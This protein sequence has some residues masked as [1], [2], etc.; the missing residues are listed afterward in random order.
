MLGFIV[1]V[2]MCVARLLIAG[3]I[4]NLIIQSSNIKS[5]IEW[6][7]DPKRLV[8]EELINLIFKLVEFPSLEDSTQTEKVGPD[9]KGQVTENLQ[10]VEFLDACQNFRKI[11]IFIIQ[12]SVFSSKIVIQSMIVQMSPAAKFVI[13]VQSQ[14]L[15]IGLLAGLLNPNFLVP[16]SVSTQTMAE[17]HVT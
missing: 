10:I 1:V 2:L 5:Q 8:L 6:L 7:D 15:S 16:V 11:I 3:C 4:I 13:L 12:I 14:K 9:K 17:L